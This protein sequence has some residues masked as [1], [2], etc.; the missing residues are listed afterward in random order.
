MVGAPA[1]ASKKGI[2]RGT[3]TFLASLEKNNKRPWFEAH[4]AQYERDVRD[5]SVD[6]V[7]GFAP[8]LRKLSPHF[9]AEAKPVG[10]S[11]MRLHRDLRFSKDKTPYRTSI[12]I[13]FWHEDASDEGEAPVWYVHIAPKETFVGGGMWQPSGPTLDKVRRAIQRDPAAWA[14]A[15]RSV[16]L[17]GEQLKRPPKGVPEDHPLVEDLKRKQFLFSQ[18]VPDAQVASPKFPQRCFAVM[19]G[20]EPMMEFLTR[21]AGLRY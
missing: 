21:A 20:Q 6:F 8:H 10:G 2:N 1:A 11:I 14:K 13:H 5:A 16:D 4:R 15:K 18:Q 7:K 9:I 19:R 17:E 3:L 12:G